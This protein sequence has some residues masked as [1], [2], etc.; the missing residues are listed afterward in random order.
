MK[1]VPTRPLVVPMLAPLVALAFVTAASAQSESDY[2]TIGL[3]ANVGFQKLGSSNGL[4]ELGF[5]VPVH[6]TKNLSVGP[7][8]QL[9]LAQDVVNLLVTANARWHFDFM[10]RTRWNRVRPFA[11]GGLGLAYTKVGGAKAT[12]FTINMGLGFE[13]P[14][15]DHV[16]MGSDVMFS[17]ILTR[18]AGGNWVFSWQFATL[19]YRF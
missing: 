12:D 13:V 19:R 14:I 8:M 16:T 7:W 10:E 5:D 1:R 6:L 2:P 17:P 4:F 9:G 18:P 15:T 3:G 11:Q